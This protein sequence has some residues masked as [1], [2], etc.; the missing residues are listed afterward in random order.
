MAP[1]VRRASTSPI[2]GFDPPSRHHFKSGTCSAGGI[3]PAPF[4][5]SDALDLTEIRK[6]PAARYLFSLACA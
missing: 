3:H 6:L 4:D 5:P 1:W 2:G